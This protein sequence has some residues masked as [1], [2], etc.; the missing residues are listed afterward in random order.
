M[1]PRVGSLPAPSGRAK[2]SPASSPSAVVVASAT[3]S[4][5]AIPSAKADDK[6]YTGPAA[7]RAHAAD[8]DLRQAR[9]LEEGARLHP[10]RR[11]GRSR[12]G[13]IKDT[14][15]KCS[16]GWYKL[17]DGGYVCG[18]YATLDLKS[19]QIRLG[20][21]T[22][23]SLEDLL[24]TSTRCSSAHGTPLYDR[25]PPARTCSRTTPV[26][27]RRQ[28]GEAQGR[29][30]EGAR[31]GEKDDDAP[32]EDPPQTD[33]AADKPDTLAKAGPRSALPT[34]TPARPEEKPWWQQAAE[35]GKP[36]KVKLDDLSRDADGTLAKRMV[37]G[38]F[39]AVDKTFAWN[40]RA[41]YKTTGGL[42]APSGPDVPGQGAPS[43]RRDG[44][45]S[46]G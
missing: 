4:A 29:Q 5:S 43:G 35:K 18:R 39:V 41:W 11:Q 8:A 40:N 20:G 42:V 44:R 15:G 19:P 7:R 46:T 26:P 21:I 24:R 32:A 3:P 28:E 9:V 10:P 33:S 16:A 38:F 30:G 34:P 13:R 23:P 22:A 27:R 17:V 36:I 25:S 31:E 6:P 14:G 2:T 12:P 45:S 1:P 37:K